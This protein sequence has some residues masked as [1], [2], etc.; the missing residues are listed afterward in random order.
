[1]KPSTAARRKLRWAS[2]LR[3]G[4]QGQAHLPVGRQPVQILSG[5]A[6]PAG[7]QASCQGLVTQR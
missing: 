5:W 6:A 3:P 2:S 7:C 4:D 1:M